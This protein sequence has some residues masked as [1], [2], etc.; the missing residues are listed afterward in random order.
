MPRLDI[1]CGNSL[2]RIL[3]LIQSQSI[4]DALKLPAIIRGKFFL[5]VA[6]QPIKGFRNFFNDLARWC[7]IAV[8]VYKS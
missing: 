7:I 5:C 2:P 1:A 8:T 3:V 4:A 6:D